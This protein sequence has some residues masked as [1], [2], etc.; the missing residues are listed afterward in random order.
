MTLPLPPVAGLGHSLGFA[1]ASDSVGAAVRPAGVAGPLFEWVRPPGLPRP[2]DPASRLGWGYR[3]GLLRPELGSCLPATLAFGAA[4]AFGGGDGG[5]V[6]VG[7]RKGFLAPWAWRLRFRRPPP[8]SSFGVGFSSP[9][10]S[11]ATGMMPLACKQPLRLDQLEVV[12]GGH[13]GF[14]FREAVVAQLG[15]QVFAGHAVAL[16]EIVDAYLFTQVFACQLG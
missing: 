5:Q 16:C 4:F 11:L 1:S 6:R 7:I 8:A 12:Q 14:G 2:P 9:A 10:V 15:G 13:V 3:S